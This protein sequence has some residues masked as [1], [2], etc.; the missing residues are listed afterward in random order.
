MFASEFSLHTLIMSL[1]LVV[2]PVLILFTIGGGLLRRQF[3]LNALPPVPMFPG[4]TFPNIFDWLYTGFFIATTIFGTV[5]TVMN[6]PTGEITVGT[7]LTNLLLQVCVY[8]PFVIRFGMLPAP[9]RPKFRIGSAAFHLF[10]ALLSIIIPFCF[11][12][13]LGFFRWLTELTGCPELQDIVVMFRDGNTGLRLTI[14]A[15]A[16]IIAPV[17]EE[18]VYRGFVYNILKRYSCR[19]VAILLSALLFSVI[20]GS[21]AQTLPL[22]VFGIAQCILYDKARSLWLPMTLHAIY[23]GLMLI[24]ILILP[25]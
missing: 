2:T 17:C 7:M 18:I 5:V 25:A 19:V 16:V 8:L 4:A 12:E 6:P 15:A 21:L 24:M 23:N 1:L 20:H 10:L 14:A 13:Q 11:L 3:S 22:L 9:I